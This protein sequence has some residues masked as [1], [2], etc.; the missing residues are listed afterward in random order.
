MSPGSSVSKRQICPAEQMFLF[1][2]I[3]GVHVAGTGD[4]ISNLEYLFELLFN[5]PASKKKQKQK[6][7]QHSVRT[8]SYSGEVL[9]VKASLQSCVHLPEVNRKDTDY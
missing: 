2:I 6:R 9:K 1:V 5:L 3:A 4:C 7:Q 8:N